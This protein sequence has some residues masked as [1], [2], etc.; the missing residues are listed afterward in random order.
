MAKNELL[1]EVERSSVWVRHGQATFTGF[2]GVDELHNFVDFVEDPRYSHTV[3]S[4]G[5]Y[6]IKSITINGRPIEYESPDILRRINS[7]FTCEGVLKLKFKKLA[8]K[9]D[10][11]V[12]D[13]KPYECVTVMNR[14]IQ[15]AGIK[16]FNA[17]ILSGWRFDNN[18]DNPKAVLSVVAG[19]SQIPPLIDKV[20][21]LPSQREFEQDVKTVG[22]NIL[23][24]FQK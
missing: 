15:V 23:E 24:G 9:V 8:G 4:N 18:P 20:M 2:S 10:F 16:G 22:K 21:G 12:I 7:E 17:K 3:F 13:Y 5:F 1:R 19:S 14:G 11:V 6:E